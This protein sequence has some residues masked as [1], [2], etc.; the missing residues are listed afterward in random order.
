MLNEYFTAYYA[1]AS[2]LLKYPT[3]IHVFSMTEGN[4]IADNLRIS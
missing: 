2:V 3:D 4:L 1:C